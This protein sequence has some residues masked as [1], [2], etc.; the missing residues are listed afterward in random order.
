MR[1][2]ERQKKKN[3]KNHEVKVRTSKKEREIIWKKADRKWERKKEDR[4]EER[5]S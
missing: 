4:K 5:E 3:N 1:C 2:I